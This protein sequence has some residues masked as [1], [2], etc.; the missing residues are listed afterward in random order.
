MSASQQHMG[1]CCTMLAGT[2]SCRPASIHSPH[3][4]SR[5]R[6]A[7]PEHCASWA[8]HGH[9]MLFTNQAGASCQALTAAWCRGAARGPRPGTHSRAPPSHSRT[10]WST[11]LCF[12]SCSG[13]PTTRCQTEGRGRWMTL[14]H[15]GGQTPSTSRSKPVVRDVHCCTYTV[16]ACACCHDP[17]H[18]GGWSWMSPTCRNVPHLQ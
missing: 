13:Q 1:L 7:L 18:A 14:L 5:S 9:C 11:T 10:S 8:A 3:L 6:Q 15:S 2:H 4:Q 17:R 16:P 12:M